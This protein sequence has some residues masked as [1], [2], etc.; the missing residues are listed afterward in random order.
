MRECGLL[1]G[2]NAILPFPMLQASLYDDCE[3]SL[4]LE[5]NVVDDSL[6]TDL[7]E[8]FDLHLTSLPYVAP[9]FCSTPMDT[10]LVT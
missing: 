9:S 5:A 3:C 7:E 2:T 10:S 4:P 8:V 1:H 6:L